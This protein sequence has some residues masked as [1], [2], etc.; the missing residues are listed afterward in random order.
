[1]GLP[2]FGYPNYIVYENGMIYSTLSNKYLKPSKNKKGYM[3]VELFNDSGS[4]RLLVHRIVAT[5][6]IENPYGL[7]QVNHI[8]EDKGNNNVS[9]LEWCTAKYNMN[10]GNGAKTRHSKID[11]SKPSYKENAI[12]NGKVVSIPVLQID[13]YGNVINRFGSIKEATDSLG[14][15]QSH[16]SEC[17]KGKRKTSWG[18]SW[19][20]ERSDDLSVYQYWF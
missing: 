10:Y 7:P 3:T 20:Y 16:I 17:C 13:K 18:F 8:D 15:K 2:V 1:M 4:K 9:N 6:F 19:K 11:Y 5:A 14:V 12:K